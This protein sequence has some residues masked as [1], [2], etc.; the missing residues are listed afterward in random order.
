MCQPFIVQPLHVLVSF[1]IHNSNLSAQLFLTCYL[2]RFSLSLSLS[3]Q[4]ATFDH[5]L[6]VH[7]LKCGFF[8][9]SVPNLVCTLLILIQVH[10]SVCT[11]VFQRATSPF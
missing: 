7:N 3:H 8:P 2:Q 1:L 4:C 11:Y 9:S 6:P 10:N 5:P